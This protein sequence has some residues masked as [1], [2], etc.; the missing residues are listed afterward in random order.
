MTTGY[1][2]KVIIVVALVTAVTAIV[3][4]ILVAATIKVSKDEV[5]RGRV[6]HL[7]EIPVSLG[8]ISELSIRGQANYVLRRGYRGYEIG[9]SGVTSDQS[10]RE[11]CGQTSLEIEDGRAFG[12]EAW[13]LTSERW[14]GESLVVDFEANDAYA[15]GV[16]P[17]VGSV[18]ARFRDK[19]GAFTIIVRRENRRN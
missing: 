18:I 14:A 8:S 11:L 16:I 10:F 6:N 17:D 4:A 2:F 7:D 9:M 5:S 13:V 19:D 12:T 15:F 1:R 3:A